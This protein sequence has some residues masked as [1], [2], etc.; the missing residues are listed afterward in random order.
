M[1][2][3]VW[4]ADFRSLDVKTGQWE[5]TVNGQ[6][7]GMP[8]IPDEVLNRLTPEQRAKMQAAMQ[9]NSGSKA[10]VSRHCTTSK[11]LEKGFNAA[12]QAAAANSCSRLVVTSTSSKQEIRMDCTS[13]GMKSSGSIKVE[14]VDSEHVKGSIQMTSSNDGH[15]MNMNYT[16]VSKW[17][18]PACSEK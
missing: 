11:D 18:G 1:C 8:P 13:G 2:S 9:A 12:D 6:T 16:F 14:A 10:S 17:V 4:A 5:T 7:T 3:A 15:T